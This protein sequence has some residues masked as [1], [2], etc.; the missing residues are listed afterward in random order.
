MVLAD[1][2]HGTGLRPLLAFPGMQGE[3]DLVTN[4]QFL[5]STVGHGITVKIDFAAI[6]GVDETV[7]PL[8]DD[9]R[10]PAVGW[11]LMRLHVASLPPDM[12]LELTPYGVETIADRN[13]DV[14]VGVVLGRISLH[15]DLPARHLEVDP[16]VIEIAATAPLGCL[17]DDATAHDTAEELLELA[18]ALADLRLDRRRGVDIAKGDLKPGWHGRLFLETTSLQGNAGVRFEPSQGGLRHI[19]AMLIKFRR[20]DGDG[21]GDGRT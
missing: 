2:R 16:D 1:E 21:H 5:E 8:G 13:V 6:A 18:G 9:A 4:P 11:N 10:D 15:D 3:P 14:L 17:D 19:F 12:V 7:V 20:S